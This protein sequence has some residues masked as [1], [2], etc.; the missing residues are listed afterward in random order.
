MAKVM[1]PIKNSNRPFN[2][3]LNIARK[4]TNPKFNSIEEVKK[5]AS[6]AKHT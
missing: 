3:L 1:R 4:A 6:N 5:A 2:R